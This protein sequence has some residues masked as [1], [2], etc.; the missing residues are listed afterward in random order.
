LRRMVECFYA[1]PE[2]QILLLAYTNRAVD[3]ICGSLESI[4]PRIDYIRIG[5]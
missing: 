4:S 2:T 3:E 5:S 1:Q